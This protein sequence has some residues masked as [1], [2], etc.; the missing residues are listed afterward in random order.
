[1]YPFFAASHGFSGPGQLKQI[2]GFVPKMLLWSDVGVL[3]ISGSMFQMNV[4]MCASRACPPPVSC[5]VASNVAN[6]LSFARLD[7]VCCTFCVP[8]TS[9]R[10][11]T[12]VSLR[13]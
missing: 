8:T 10:S 12:T 11:D 3:A 6:A 13:P 4:G 7:V 5:C 1:M 2:A 9:S